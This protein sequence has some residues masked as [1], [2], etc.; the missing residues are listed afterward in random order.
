MQPELILQR[1]SAGLWSRVLFL[2]DGNFD[3]QE[4]LLFRTKEEDSFACSDHLN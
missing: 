1:V 4:Q 2:L 3:T